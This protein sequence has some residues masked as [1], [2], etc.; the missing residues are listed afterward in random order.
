MFATAGLILDHLLHSVGQQIRVEAVPD[1]R[2]SGLQSL[3]P[4]LVIVRNI[5]TYHCVVATNDRTAIVISIV[6]LDAD[7]SVVMVVVTILVV[8][9]ASI[10]LLLLLLLSLAL[11]FNVA[12]VHTCYYY[13]TIFRSGTKALAYHASVQQCSDNGE[14]S[15][16]EPV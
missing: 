13:R 2:S 15:S 16:I 5:Y 6:S 4:I 14:A 8:V 9:G 11:L 7:T 3:W 12:A 1:V 10:L